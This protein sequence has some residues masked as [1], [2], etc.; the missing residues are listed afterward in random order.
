MR[1]G[2]LK[3]M[4]LRGD[5]VLH[6]TDPAFSRIKV[7]LA[8]P[9]VDYGADLQLKQHPHVNKF[10]AGEPRIITLKNA[11]RGFPTNQHLSVLKWR[12]TGKDES[13]IPLTSEFGN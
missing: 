9:S 5:M 12:Y 3:S 1:E 13:F 10:A 4:E 7:K 11:D 6:I 2:G 8:E